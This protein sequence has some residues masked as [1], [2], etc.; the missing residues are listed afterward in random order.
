MKSFR[1]FCLLRSTA[2]SGQGRTRFCCRIGSNRP[3]AAAAAAAA[4]GPRTQPYVWM[5]NSCEI[6]EDFIISGVTFERDS[7]SSVACLRCG[8]SFSAARRNISMQQM[9]G[10]ADSH[11]R[12]D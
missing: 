12:G 8:H 10:H 11:V 4:V 3:T 9:T 2:P 5:V 1:L 7:H 6:G